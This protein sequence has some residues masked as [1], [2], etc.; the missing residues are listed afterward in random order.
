LQKQPLSK[1]GRDGG[2]RGFTPVKENYERKL[3]KGGSPTQTNNRA[4]KYY[5]LG[6]TMFCFSKIP[7]NRKGD[8]RQSVAVQTFLDKLPDAYAIAN[9]LDVFMDYKELHLHAICECIKAFLIINPKIRRRR[10]GRSPDDR[11][12]LRDTTRVCTPRPPSIT[13]TTSIACRIERRLRSE[14]YCCMPMPLQGEKR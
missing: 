2:C 9:K 4:S 10:I 14:T 1:K 8:M 13:S 5:V 12:M 11:V 7:L 3:P 6:T